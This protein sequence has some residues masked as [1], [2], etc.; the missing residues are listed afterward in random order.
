MRTNKTPFTDVCTLITATVTTDADG[1]ETK[2]LTSRNV[3]CNVVNGVVRSEFYEAYKAGIQASATVEI[4]EE[5][6]QN[7][8]ALSLDNKS[9]NVVRV[10]P[11]GYGTLE[12][13]LTEVT[14]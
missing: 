2:T 5:D 12:L 7:E 11:T 14:R 4:Y 6:Y 8:T 10:Y 1:F 13:T 9:Y 3:F